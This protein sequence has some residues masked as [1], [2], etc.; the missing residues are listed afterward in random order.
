MQGVF[1]VAN[2][3]CFLAGK[4]NGFIFGSFTFIIVLFTIQVVSNNPRFLFLFP[5]NIE[6]GVPTPSWDTYILRTLL[7]MSVLLFYVGVT[8]SYLLAASIPVVAI[9][10]PIIWDRYFE[11]HNRN[12]IQNLINRDGS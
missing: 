3:A 6:K 4:I 2:I 1:L 11:K 7:I 10:F 5:V 9:G 8:G 12:R